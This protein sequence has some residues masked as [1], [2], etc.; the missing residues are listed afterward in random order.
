MMSDPEIVRMLGR[1]FKQYRLRLDY[2]QRDVAYKTGLSIATIHKFES[3]SAL[4]ISLGALLAL[5]RCTNH[6]AEIENIF[7]ELPPSP[8]LDM[9]RGKLKQRVKPKGS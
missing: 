3:G 2:T 6:L 1:R 8:Y 5:M 4:N 7:P 9:R